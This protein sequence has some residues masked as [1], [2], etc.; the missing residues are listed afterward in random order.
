MKLHTRLLILIYFGLLSSLVFAG[1]TGKIS[2]NVI[3]ASTGEGL[4][5]ANVFINGT[6]MGAATDIDGHFTILNV[7]PGVYSVTASVVGYQ[8]QTIK[9]IRV[10]VDFTTNLEFKLNPGSVEMAAI[11]VEGDRNP[12]IRQ[13]LTNPTVAITSKTIDELPVDQISD[14]IRLQ[15]GVSVSDDGKIHIRGGY[16]NEIA[17]T[18]NGISLNDPYGNQRSIGLATNAV[19]E[20]SVSTGTFNAEYGN[21]LS[22]VVN[23]VTKEGGDKLSFSLRGYAGDYVTSHS[24]LFTNI[25]DIDPVNRG[26]MEATLG[27]PIP[28]TNNKLKIFVSSVYENFKGSLYGKRLYNPSDSYLS[29]ESFRD[30]DPRKGTP[31]DPY[32][33]NPYNSN[34]KG[35]PTGGGAIVPMNPSENWNLQGNM[36]YRLSS[37]VKLRYEAVYNKGKYQKYIRSYKFNPNGRRTWRAEGLIQTLDLTHTVN[38]NMFYTLKASYGYNQSEAYLYKNLTDSRYLPPLYRRTV[39]NTTFLAGGTDNRRFYRKTET[40]TVK[41]DLVAQLFTSHEV[42]AGFEARFH[43]LNV[44]SFSVEIGKQNPDGSFGTLTNDDILYDST[45]TL[46]RRKPTSPA[47]ITQ[48]TK[49]PVDGA[50]YIQDKIE[51]AKTLILNIGLRYEYFDPKSVYNPELNQDLLSEQF[52]FITKNAEAAKIK[53]RLSPRISISY[54]ITDRGVIRFSYGHFYQ[55]GS[56][57]RLYRNPEFFVTNV[58]STPTFGNPN[59]NLQRSVQYEIGLQQQLTD[60]FKF[61]LTGFY[62]DVRDYIF[63]QSVFTTTGREFRILTNLAYS[64]VRGLTLSLT[65]RRSRD[66]MFY[67]NLDYTFQVAEGNRTYPADDLF[68]SEASGKQSETYLVPLSFDR[69]HIINASFGLYDQGNWTLGVIANFQTGTPYTP[70]LPTTIPRVITYIQNSGRKTIQWNVDF[71]FEKYFEVG[72]FRYSLFLQVQ[73]L[74]DTENERLVYNSTGRALSAVEETSN[75]FQFTDIKKRINRSDPG[76][77]GIDEIN[78]YYSK[79]PERI[80]RPREVRLGFS[81]IF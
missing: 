11:V 66:G 65:Q 52:G 64:N 72:N 10:N 3:D 18:L 49:Y 74:F 20:V 43:K 63:T 46:I 39:G 27:G 13:D 54:P 58:G 14:V 1:S 68:F 53:Q 42:K 12:L 19:Q 60:N 67:A 77:F 45:L 80:S 34:S 33:F 51:L 30:G 2:G 73:N 44:E 56:L 48:Y 9:D 76:L 75:S 29:P 50:V 71:K 40:A 62:K 7:P 16:G 78:G 38:A 69:Q 47:L 17:Y 26:R 24:D 28:F 70:I 36:S 55:N 4:P 79:R 32:I 25:D 35:L 5:F 81:V 23:Y 8:K 61:D 59:V 57:S 31:T 37:L 21:A 15:A 6:G 41:G 22:G